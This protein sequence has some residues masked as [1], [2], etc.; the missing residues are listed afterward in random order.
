MILPPLRYLRP[1]SLAEAVDA[2]SDTP[3]AAVLAGGQTLITMLKLD[4][5]APAA[6]I[7]VHRLDE[8]RGIDLAPDGAL[9]IGAAST[10]RE[11]ATSPVV[12]EH[13]PAVATMAAGMVDRQV[14]NRG[15]L[16]G[17]CCLNDPAS[18]FPPLLTALG[19]T[20]RGTGPARHAD[21]FFTGT[22][23]TALARDEIL[24]AVQLPALPRGTLVEHSHQQ[25]GADS[26][27]IARAVVRLDVT[28]R[29]ITG[30][31]VVLGAVLGSPLRLPTVE[32]ALVGRP[33]DGSL[34][35]VADLAADVEIDTVD[36][37]HCTAGY[38]REMAR[39]QLRRALRA[40]VART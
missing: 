15:T 6:L 26:W 8:L 32:D 27:A 11:I 2:L 14:R 40:A 13:Q 20:F 4:L 16:G 12:R 5:V 35:D 33:L 1:G 7:D 30:A 17:N 28:D 31:R 19:A 34:P 22:L 38:R 39:V 29:V 18:N 36:D 3:D 10:Y 21:D 37:A 23:A 25:V 24:S 9:V